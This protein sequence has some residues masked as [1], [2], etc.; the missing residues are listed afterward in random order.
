MHFI[1]K[2]V[3]VQ[4]YTAAGNVALLAFDADRRAAVRRAAA[5]PLLLNAVQQSI[6]IS[7]PPGPRQQTR[8]RRTLLQLGYRQTDRQTDGQTDE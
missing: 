6:D 5:A 2:H 1:C 3:C 4:P 8:P 7:C